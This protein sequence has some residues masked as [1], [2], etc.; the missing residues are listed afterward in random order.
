MNLQSNPKLSFPCW[1]QG[2]S[3]GECSCRPW[4]GSSPGSKAQAVG[5]RATGGQAGRPVASGNPSGSHAA[6]TQCRKDSCHGPRASQQAG[7]PRVRLSPSGCRGKGA[8]T[9]EPRLA[10][11]APETHRPILEVWS[12]QT[13]PSCGPSAMPISKDWFRNSSRSKPTP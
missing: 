9:N 8:G 5:L 12:R 6:E 4:A 2:S 1:A 13:Y 7:R 3:P 10:P 11:P